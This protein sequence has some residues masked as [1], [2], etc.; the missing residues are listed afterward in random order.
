[1]ASSSPSA[2]NLMYRYLPLERTYEGL[3][4]PQK[5]PRIGENTKGPSR[6]SMWSNLHS[7]DGSIEYFSSKNKSMHCRGEAWERRGVEKKWDKDG[8]VGNVALKNKDGSLTF[9]NIDTFSLRRVFLWVVGWGEIPS[10]RLFYPGPTLP[11]WCHTR[12]VLHFKHKKEVKIQ[13]AEER[14]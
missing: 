2:T 8:T 4:G 12:V 14:V 5:R 13:Q 7:Q 10:L 1:M 3:S 11:S 9:N 6:T